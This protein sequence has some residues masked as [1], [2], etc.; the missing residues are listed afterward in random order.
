MARHDLQRTPWAPA[1]QSPVGCPTHSGALLACAQVD[2]LY[3]HNV[4]EAQGALGDVELRT[5][6]AEAF[7]WLEAARTA[8]RIKV[9]TLASPQGLLTGKNPFPCV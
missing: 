8:G 9:L 6:L 3:L 4:A 1:A 7:L 5:R 2:I